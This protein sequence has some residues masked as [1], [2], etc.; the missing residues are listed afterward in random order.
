M[1]TYSRIQLAEDKHQNKIFWIKSF[2]TITIN[3][4]SVDKNTTILFMIASMH[5]YF[6]YF[7]ENPENV[8]IMTECDGE[9]IAVF[10]AFVAVSRIPKFQQTKKDF[11][12]QCNTLP[13]RIFLLSVRMP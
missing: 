8:A 7:R 6:L 3:T 12:A 9:V 13:L 5:Q 1:D 11:E 10:L 2:S 4:H